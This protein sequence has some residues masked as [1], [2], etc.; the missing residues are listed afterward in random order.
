MGP[1]QKKAKTESSSSASASSSS[2]AAISEKKTKQ[3]SSLYETELG[4]PVAHVDNG[5]EICEKLIKDTGVAQSSIHNRI[6][7]SLR[8]AKA[9]SEGVK[10]YINS[11]I[12]PSIVPVGANNAGKSYFVNNLTLGGNLEEL[13]KSIGLE[14]RVKEYWANHFPVRSSSGGGEALTVLVTRIQANRGKAREFAARLVFTSSSV[15]HRRLGIL[16]ESSESETADVNLPNLQELQAQLD[17]ILAERF[18][19]RTK[20]ADGRTMELTKNNQPGMNVFEE[21]FKYRQLITDFEKDIAA[22]SALSWLIEVELEGPFENLRNMKI[23][24]LDVSFFF[25]LFLFSS[26]F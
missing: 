2:S 4:R 13:G 22:T 20:S 15:F 14:K 7:E 21:L 9:V 17:G 23:E 1:P 19:E 3:D 5:I 8:T 12:I 26:L 24:L 25:L 6:S 18:P 10:K 16:K 11:E